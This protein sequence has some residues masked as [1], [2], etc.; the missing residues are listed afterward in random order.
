VNGLSSAPIQFPVTAA[1]PNLFVTPGSYVTNFREFAAVALN[2]DG[3]VNSSTNPAAL[4]SVI[5]VFVNGLA[6]NPNVPHAPH[7]FLS[8]GGWSVTNFFQTSPFVLEVDLRVPSSTANLACRSN[9]CIAPFGVG[10]LSA[11]AGTNLSFGGLVYV[12]Q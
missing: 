7:F 4:G 5:S 2:A 1:N 9:V 10:D 8:G 11:P 3:S 6:T 12:S